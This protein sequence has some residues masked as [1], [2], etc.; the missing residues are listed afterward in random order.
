MRKLLFTL[1]FAV[2]GI[3]ASYAQKNDRVKLSPDEKAEK[4]ATAMQTKLSLNDDQKSKIKQIELDRI[5]QQDE[6][7]KSDV[8]KMKGKIEERKAAMKAHDEKI[9]AVLTPEQQK[10][11]AASKEEMKGKLKERMRD[12]KGRANKAPKAEENNN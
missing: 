6:L 7:R 9:N 10:T 3:T 12:R 4:L 11:Y 2:L 1:A 8:E 5:K